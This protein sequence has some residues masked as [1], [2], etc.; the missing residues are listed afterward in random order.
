[1]LIKLNPFFHAYARHREEKVES[2]MTRQQWIVVDRIL[3]V[4]LFISVIII[5]IAFS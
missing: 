1:M 3:M 2:A 4:V 5:A